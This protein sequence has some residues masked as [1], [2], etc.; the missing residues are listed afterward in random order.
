MGELLFQQTTGHGVSSQLSKIVTAG[1]PPRNL[2]LHS[3]SLVA[4]VGLLF[5]LLIPWQSWAGRALGILPWPNMAGQ[6]PPQV[7][8]SLTTASQPFVVVRPFICLP[9]QLSAKRVGWT[10]G[11]LPLPLLV[12]TLPLNRREFGSHWSK[13]SGPP[14]QTTVIFFPPVGPLGH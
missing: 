10:L 7:L 13:I 1:G 4:P 5:R 3:A 8:Q 14:L 11:P 9:P 12:V 6:P 2:V